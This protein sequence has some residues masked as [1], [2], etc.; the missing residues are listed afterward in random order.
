MPMTTCLL[1]GLVFPFDFREIIENSLIAVDLFVADH[2]N[3]GPVVVQFNR[4]SSDFLCLVFDRLNRKGIAD[5][6]FDVSELANKN[7]IDFLIAVEVQVVD[8][9]FFVQ[10]SF[11]FLTGSDVLDQS[12]HAAKIESFARGSIRFRQSR[13]VLSLNWRSIIGQPA[14]ERVAPVQNQ[15][16]YNGYF[17]RFHNGLCQKCWYDPAVAD[18]NSM[19]PFFQ[20][21]RIEAATCFLLIS[22]PLNRFFGNM[23]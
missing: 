13:L 4:Y 17:D 1:F 7:I 20:E 2:L 3:F 21:K 15:N 14:V 12:R 10:S 18:W 22:L 16:H 11:Q 9:V 19:S 23:S 5:F 6:L 8:S